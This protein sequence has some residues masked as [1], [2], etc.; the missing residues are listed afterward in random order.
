MK[1]VFLG[2]NCSYSHTSLAAWCLRA[3][4]DE[5]VFDWQTVE[6]TIK[7]DP[8]RVLAQLTTANPDVLAA[9]LYLFNHEFVATIL[10]GWR[11]RHPA[12]RIVVGGPE[13]LGANERLA[14]PSGLADLA[15]RGEGERAFP[16]LLERWRIGQDWT[17]IPGLCGVDSSGVFRDNGVALSVEALD[18][19]PSFYVRELV[20]F[21]KPFVQLE[22]SRGCANGCLFCTS[23]FTAQ[24]THSLD[25]VRADLSAITAA[26][27]RD[28]RIVDR[29]F[30]EDRARALSLTRLF[31]D[32]FPGLRFH[33]EIEP[34][35]FNQ[36]LAA[37][38]AK[39]ASGRFHLEAGV[40]TLVPAVCKAIERGATV[41]RTL[42]GLKR[43]CSLENTEVH[44]DLIAGLPGGRL[45][46]IQADLET[47][48]LLGPAEIQ[49]ERLKLLPG[50]P[51]AQDPVRWGLRSN[52]APPYQVLETDTLSAEEL[53]QADRLSKLADWYYNTRELHV[54]LVDAVRIDPEWLSKFETWVRD[55]MT[56]DIRPSLESRFKTLH[57]FLTLQIQEGIGAGLE[58][59]VY[60]L[61]YRWFR[62]GFSARNGICPA[63][64]WKK[65]IPAGAELV[66][67]DA[68]AKVA[69]KWLVDLEVPYLFCYGTGPNGERA[70]VAVYRF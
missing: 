17:D 30:N 56:C 61:C 14:G 54:L 45:T 58:G 38:F 53:R 46:D 29:T 28:V 1:V 2:V 22:T 68:K 57:A 20:D 64:M 21:R 65:E 51:F 50:T 7:D 6:V 16:E 67:G 10:K 15:V 42:E 60:R 32:E 36:E 3:M 41:T 59:V 37:E 49:L 47:I 31:R 26:G 24:R 27:V 66:E 48:M 23:R 9:T 11:T 34:A 55:Q 70:V 44:V 43:L 4:I 62:L 39:A 5:S 25:R 19:I 52:G 40:Q 63:V 33:L 13:C 8:E 12:A 35:R 69:R 18:S